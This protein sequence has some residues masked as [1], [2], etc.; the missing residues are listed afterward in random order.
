ME[1]NAE[2]YQKTCGRVTEHGV[3]LFNI[4]KTLPCDKVLDIGCGTGELTKKIAA[5]AK[6][7]IGIDT[8]PNMIE[9]AKINYPELNLMVM[10]AC[11]LQ[12]ENYF[13]TVFSN[14]V[15]HFIKT[16]DAL[17]DNIY[18]ALK[19][20]G[21]LVCEF[22]AFGNIAGLLDAVDYAYSKRG[23]SYSLRFFYPAEG[24]YRFLLEKH[25]FFVENL[26]VYDLDTKLIEGEAGLRNW[27]NQIFNVEM[28][29]FSDSE[30]EDV[31]TEIESTLRALQWDGSNWHLPN[32]RLQFVARKI[33]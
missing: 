12:W 28:E 29:W 26:S 17:L 11:A 16:Q 25:G 2:K 19:L 1:W 7:T 33:Q 14:A 6:E 15:F 13:D 20:N 21:V 31:L 23:K 4:L 32:R 10:N 9:K 27:I 24:E 18:R 30:L 8:S 5:F 22:G 3:K